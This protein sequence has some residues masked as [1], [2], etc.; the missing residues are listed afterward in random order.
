MRRNACCL[1][2]SSPKVRRRSSNHL[3]VFAQVTQDRQLHC[4]WEPK[5]VA[6][7]DSPE[8]EACLDMSGTVRRSRHSTSG[9]VLLGETC[10]K[11]HMWS[12]KEHL[13]Y[14]RSLS[15]GKMP[16]SSASPEPRSP[17]NMPMKTGFQG[18]VSRR[19]RR[20]TLKACGRACERSGLK[21][22]P[23]LPHEIEVK[24][25]YFTSQLRGC[26]HGKVTDALG[27]YDQEME[28]DGPVSVH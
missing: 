20:R 17:S 23:M 26:W 15:G 28:L 12:Q 16:L 27:G 4:R 5:S 9:R 18:K 3:R 21:A 19:S 14:E 7:V 13:S 24:N 8:I 2:Q 22:L 6:S 11:H 1:R 10:P 25:R